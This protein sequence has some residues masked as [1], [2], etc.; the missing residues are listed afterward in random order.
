MQVVP[1]EYPGPG[2]DCSDLATTELLPGFGFFVGPCPE[3]YLLAGSEMQMSSGTSLSR[4][5]TGPMID[6]QT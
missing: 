6:C 4:D 5:E 3:D 2:S 1:R